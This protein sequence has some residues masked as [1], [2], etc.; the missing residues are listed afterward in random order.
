MEIDFNSEYNE[1]SSIIWRG[2]Y[3]LDDDEVRD[4]KDA[5]MAHPESYKADEDADGNIWSS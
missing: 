5:L 2:N 4:V 3:L 1:E